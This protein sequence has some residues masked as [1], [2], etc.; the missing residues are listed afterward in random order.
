MNTPAR[1]LARLAG[2]VS[3]ALPFAA[4]GQSGAEAAAT[5]AHEWM[6][7]LGAVVIDSPYAGEGTRLRPVPLL[8]YEGERVFVRGTVAGVHVWRSDRVTVD[9]V[10]A[11]R[12]DGF[13]IGD[14]GRDALRRNGLDPDRLVDRDDGLDAGLR[15]TLGNRWGAWSIGAVHDVTD[16]SGGYEVAVDY[17]YS[18]ARGDGVFTANAG[19]SLLSGDLAGYYYGTLDTEV[20][21][22]VDAYVPG[23]A[24]VHRIGMDWLHPVGS[25]WH[26][27]A[28]VSLTRL[29]TV[30]RDSP[31][32]D[33]DRRHAGR[34]FVGFARQF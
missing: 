11:A 29:P 27:V 6:V 8:G 16:T 14:L 31:L 20:A 21:R 13:D 22:G 7:G 24:V 33:Q 26:V 30:L 2:A 10:A 32:L 18:W 9:V 25:T 28:A 23:S 12:L 15:V 34:L 19:S 1:R 5:P 17:R 3:L 4:L